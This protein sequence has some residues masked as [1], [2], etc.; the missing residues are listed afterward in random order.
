MPY[1]TKCGRQLQDGEVCSCIDANTQQIAHS[2]YNYVNIPQQPYQNYQNQPNSQGFAPNGYPYQYYSQP[3]PPK[4]ESKAWI[5]AIIIPVGIIM[6]MIFAAI[7]IP[8]TLGY[9]RKSKMSVKNEYAN[10]IRKAATTSIIELE[11]EGE[12][13]KGKYI[14]CSNNNDNV[15][16]PFNIAAFNEKFNYYTSNESLK[17]NEYFIVVVDG[18][19]VYTAVSEDWTNPKELV[20]TYPPSTPTGTSLY[21][22]DGSTSMSTD[23]KTLDY[24]YWD[25]YDKIFNK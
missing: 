8:A 20:G 17:K 15:A 12:K 13:V 1:C 5:L 3:I 7:F 23:K 16:V 10:H 25:T 11:E 22:V 14:I 4:K 6:L 18:V 24:L 9:A 21:T 19:A 2:Q